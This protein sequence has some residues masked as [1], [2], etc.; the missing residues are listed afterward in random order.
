MGTEMDTRRY[1]VYNDNNECF[2]S[3][4]VTLGNNAGAQLKGIFGQGPMKFFEGSWITRP[5]GLETVGYLG[6][7]DLIY[8]DNVHRVVRVLEGFPRFRIAPSLGEA[9]SML[10]LPVST[11]ESSQTQIGDQLAIYIAEEME[12]HL[13]LME[14]RTDDIDLRPSNGPS[15]D[16][17]DWLS[18]A[19]RRDRRIAPRKRWP[20]LE[21]YDTESSSVVPHA[22]RDIST[23]GLYLMTDE[24]WPLG[25][26][27]RMSLQRTDGLDDTSMI[28]TTIE[29]RVSRWGA[30]GVGLEFV[31]ADADHCA[32]VSAHV[33]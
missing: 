17:R 26:R 11:I 3:L 16:V 21:A 12:L 6:A 9:T 15:A 20:R 2:L 19:P 5:A 25:T 14:H 13:R 23:T 24:R 31:T 29:L 33:R 4:G 7:R 22:V 30:D 32:L 1:C 8:I 28:P 10:A 27:V 18:Q